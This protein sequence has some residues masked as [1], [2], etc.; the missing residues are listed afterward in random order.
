MSSAEEPIKLPLTK[1]QQEMIHRLTG[2]HAAVL[3]LTPDAGDASAGT[4]CGL[5]FNWRISVDSG[6]PRQQW[7]TAVKPPKAA[8]D[9]GTSA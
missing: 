9:G 2:E 8:S 5:R 4:G 6:I 1:E 7:V 3:E